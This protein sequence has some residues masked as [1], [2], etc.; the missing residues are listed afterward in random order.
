[1]ILTSPEVTRGKLTQPETLEGQRYSS[2]FH[3]RRPDAPC[4]CD[5]CK[6]EPLNFFFPTDLEA[7]WDSQYVGCGIYFTSGRST[8][9]C[10]IVASF[11]S[12]G[13]TIGIC[14]TDNIKP[15]VGDTFILIP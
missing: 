2:C 9:Q 11:G 1:M 8:G 3:T 7:M 12:L 6:Y 15:A 14:L 5:M 4:I 13:S 10:F